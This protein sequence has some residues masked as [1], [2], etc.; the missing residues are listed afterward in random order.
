MKQSRPSRWSLSV[1]SLLLLVG[2][3]SGLA[4]DNAQRAKRSDIPPTRQ[5][6]VHEIIGTSVTS[7]LSESF[8]G[9]TF[10]PA[11]W[12]KISPDGGTGWNRQLNGTTPVPGWTGGTITVPTGG[13]NATAFC[14]WT[15]G[16]AAANDQWLVTPQLTN[17]L[18][19]DTL[20]FWMRWWPNNFADT[21]QVRIS[22]TTP[23]VANFTTLVATIGFPANGLDTGWIRYRYRLSNFV[24]TG[25]NIYVG[26]REKVGDNQTDGASISIDLVQVTVS[27]GVDDPQNG[28]PSVFALH[29]NYPNPFNPSTTIGFSVPTASRVSLK[30]YN[31]LGEAVATLADGQYAPGTHTVQWNATGFSSGVYFYKLETGNFTQTRKLLLAK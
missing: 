23:T 7:A 12:L 15:T 9:T 17:V 21:V 16:G 27:T 24:P 4:G 26:F 3:V 1:L 2:T 11:G 29:Q 30:V 25:S 28:A 19:N 6:E 8:E 10:P 5:A 18:A 14:T 13:G 31:L 20:S 22:T